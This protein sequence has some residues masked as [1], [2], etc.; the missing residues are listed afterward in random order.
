MGNFLPSGVGET[1]GDDLATSSPI[2][3]S[4]NVWFVQSTTGTDAASP[5]GKNKAEPLATLNQANTNAVSGDIV[6]LLSAHTETR[7]TAITITKSLTIVGCGTTSS[8]PAPQLKNNAAAASLFI[9]NTAGIYV[10]FRNIYFPAQVQS[11]SATKISIGQGNVR[12]VG[13]YFEANVFDA[14][15]VVTLPTTGTESE[16]DFDA[17]TFISTGTSSSSQPLSAISG[18]SITAH[19]R[20]DGSTFSNGTYGWSGASAVTVTGAGATETVKGVGVNLLLGATLTLPSS[21]SWVKTGTVT[22]GARVV[23]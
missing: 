11:C 1:V 20:F 19:V 21:R 22:G 7:T 8:K 2:Y 9:I 14:A 18:T 3:M 23:I 13:C 12:F 15:A 17:C 6:A 10:E 4:G 5:A 16:V